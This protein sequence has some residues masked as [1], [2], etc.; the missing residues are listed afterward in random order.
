M[1]ATKQAKKASKAKPGNVPA[2]AEETEGL[3]MSVAGHPHARRH[4]R[5]AKAWA[6]L[7]GFLVAAALSFQAGVP[8]T[9][10]GLRALACGAG[11]YL[12]GWGCSVTLWRHLMLAEV[13][14]HHARLM[15]RQQTASQPAEGML[16]IPD[17][18]VVVKPNA[19]P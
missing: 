2:G 1:A 9:Q 7:V 8:L 12:L 17:G 19:A 16:Q 3:G 13:R 6:G 4:V 10:V 18:S 15:A 11:G 14:A 5:L